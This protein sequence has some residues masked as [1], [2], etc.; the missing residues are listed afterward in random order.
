MEISEILRIFL[1]MNWCSCS[2][3]SHS[4]VAQLR[5]GAHRL[6]VLPGPL[7]DLAGELVVH[8]RLARFGNDEQR[9]VVFTEESIPRSPVEIE[10]RELRKPLAAAARLYFH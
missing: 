10:I 5:L 6:D 9:F 3:R 7:H 1:S 4:G 2:S 8:R